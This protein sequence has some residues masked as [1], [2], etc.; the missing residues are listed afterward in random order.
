MPLG[1]HRPRRAAKP[2]AEIRHRP[3]RGEDHHLPHYRDHARFQH[4]LLVIGE[5]ATAAG[6]SSFNLIAGP[7]FYL[8]HE[9]AWNYLGPPDDAVFGL[10]ALP[11]GTRETASAAVFAD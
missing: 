7:L 9:A 8:A 5:V 2:P 3:G 11:R 6:L 1:S 10:P 4:Q